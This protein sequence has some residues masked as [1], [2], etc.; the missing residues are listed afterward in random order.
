MEIANLWDGLGIGLLLAAPIGPVALLW[1]RRTLAEGWAAGLMA[2]LGAASGH[3]LLGGGVGVAAVWL[4]G[5][6]TALQ[7]IGGAVLLYMGVRL[8]GR[9]PALVGGEA[10][11]ARLGRAFGATLLLQV[12]T[13]A[14]SLMTLMS[15]INGLSAIGAGVPAVAL[16]WLVLGVFLGSALWWV[17]LTAAVSRLRE[18]ITP[19][20]MARLNVAA[21]C[22]IVGSGV[23]LIGTGLRI[24]WALG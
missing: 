2:G 6:Q 7:L 17:L 8:L 20:W 13:P 11:P 23:K 24:W 18:R 14:N 4:R 21:A 1:M 10:A 22:V 16:G 19:R 5:Q 3:A 9:R 15:Y 12:A